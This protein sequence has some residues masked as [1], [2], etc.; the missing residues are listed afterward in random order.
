MEMSNRYRLVFFDSKMES[1]NYLEKEEVAEVLNNFK[2]TDPDRFLIY[3]L[4]NDGFDYLVGYKT[5]VKQTTT[6]KVNNG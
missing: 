6:W 5:I 1:R 3:R 4:N 2:I